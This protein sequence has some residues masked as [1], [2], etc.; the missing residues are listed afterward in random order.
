MCDID[1]V[2]GIDGT[3]R[4][5]SIAHDRKEGDKGVVNDIDQVVLFGSDRNPSDEEEYPGKPK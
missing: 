2:I 1:H 4:G 5:Q 3:E